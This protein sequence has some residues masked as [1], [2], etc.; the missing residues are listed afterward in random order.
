VVT[1]ANELAGKL[2]VAWYAHAAEKL[3]RWL[4]F[5][6]RQRMSKGGWPVGLGCDAPN[7]GCQTTT[8]DWPGIEV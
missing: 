1:Q 3:S 8:P 4:K 7:K 2:H 5:L 6:V